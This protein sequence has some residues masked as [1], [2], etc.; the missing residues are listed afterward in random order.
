M[1]PPEKPATKGQLRQEIARL[2]SIGAQM[3]NVCFNW[4]QNK[5]VLDKSDRE[6]MSNLRIQWDGIERG[7]KR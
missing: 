3:S 4:S 5:K 7:E 1:T 2:R 6:L